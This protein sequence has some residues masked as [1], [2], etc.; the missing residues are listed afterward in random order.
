ML[1]LSSRRLHD[2][3][4]NLELLTVLQGLDLHNNY[5]GTFTGFATY[6]RMFVF[7]ETLDLSENELKSFPLHMVESLCMLPQLTYLNIS[8]NKISIFPSFQKFGMQSSTIPPPPP[9]PDSHQIQQ[10]PMINS[11]RV[12]NNNKSSFC[13]YRI[14]V[15]CWPQ[16]TESSICPSPPSA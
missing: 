7:L 3:P 10:R 6:M 15:H 4:P 9:S 2:L 5:F 16:T 13:P 14:F 11:L 8:K 1:D 12:K